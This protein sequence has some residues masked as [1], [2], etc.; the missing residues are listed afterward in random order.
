MDNTRKDEITQ[1]S[2]KVPI[3]LTVRA[4][5]IR[6]ARSMRLN[7]SRAAEV[8]IELALKKAKEDAWLSNSKAAIDAYNNRIQKSGT[9]LKP[10]WLQD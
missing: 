9:L 7:T 8:G 10:V 6:E 1:G 3:S 4:D 2:K 5:L